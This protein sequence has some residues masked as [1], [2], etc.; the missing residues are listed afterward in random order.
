MQIY[1]TGGLDAK[2][3]LAEG[4]LAIADNL[5]HFT[6]LNLDFN[7]AVAGA[8]TAKG[9]F[10]HDFIPPRKNSA[11]L[12]LRKSLLALRYCFRHQPPTLSS[13]ALSGGRTRLNSPRLMQGWVIDKDSGADN[14]RIRNTRS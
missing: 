10:R 8:Q 1:Q 6:L 9:P 4:A 12:I 7:A 3:T 2:L 5:G 11:R 13:F 14:R